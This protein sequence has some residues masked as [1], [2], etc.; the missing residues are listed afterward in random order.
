KSWAELEGATP[1]KSVE[2]IFSSSSGWWVAYA[3]G[4]LARFDE[5]LRAWRPIGFRE[6]MSTRKGKGRSRQAPVSRLVSKDVTSVLEE[7]GRTIAAT[8]DGLWELAKSGKEFR[9]AAGKGLPASVS[10][11]A[12]SAG[13]LLAIADGKLWERGTKLDWNRVQTPEDSG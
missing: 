10:Y 5:K 3:G 7:G 6:V 9:R 13:S 1:T 8:T 2:R 11:L 12:S 4:G